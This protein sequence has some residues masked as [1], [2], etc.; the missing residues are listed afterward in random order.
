MAANTVTINYTKFDKEQ[1]E[2]LS[3]L[4]EDVDMT[5]EAKEVSKFAKNVV[6][7]DM[8]DMLIDEE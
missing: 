5:K 4:L 8:E 7:S 1:L 3:S 2:I 6:V